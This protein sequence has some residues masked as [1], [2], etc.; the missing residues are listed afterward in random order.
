MRTEKFVKKWGKER[1]RGKKFY[2]L[3][4]SITAGLGLLTGVII[5]RLTRDS[6]NFFDLN[7]LIYMIGFIVVGL[8]GGAIGGILKWNSNEGKYNRFS[9]ND[10]HK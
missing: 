5:S 9:S 7:N 4:V 1:K 10:L 3:T 2:V 8:I 6:S